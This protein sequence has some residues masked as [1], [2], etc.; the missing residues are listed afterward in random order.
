MA[1]QGHW[2]TDVLAGAALGAGMGYLANRED[3]P[4]VLRITGNGVYA[5]LKVKF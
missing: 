1:S 2:L 4:F 3:Q 5:G